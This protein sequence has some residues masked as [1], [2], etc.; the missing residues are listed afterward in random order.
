MLTI[1]LPE[2]LLL[3]AI[4]MKYMSLAGQHYQW[5]LNILSLT[6]C[7]LVMYSHT[8]VPMEGVLR[9]LLRHHHMLASK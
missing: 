3:L 6:S 4:V 1:A 7:E 2:Y 9:G 5:E 8:I